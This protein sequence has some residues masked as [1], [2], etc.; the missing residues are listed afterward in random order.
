MKDPLYFAS[1]MRLIVFYSSRA[2]LWHLHAYT[3]RL[4]C[5]SA[6]YYSNIDNDDRCWIGLYKS[7]SDTSFFW[8]DGNPS[9]YRSRYWKGD[10]NAD[11]CVLI[12]NG[13]FREESCT[14][15]RI[16][17]YVCKGIYFFSEVIFLNVLFGSHWGRRSWLSV[18]Y[19]LTLNLFSR[20]SW[21]SKS[22]VVCVCD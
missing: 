4:W 11:Q 6:V 13:E 2:W 22:W 7:E 12:N 15:S 19:E 10:P 3:T 18:S 14:G 9:T 1:R 17:R 20:L 5:Y 21:C 16:Y 8:L